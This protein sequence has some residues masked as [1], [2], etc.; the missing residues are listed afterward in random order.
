MMM[1]PE[2][3]TYKSVKHPLFHS[4]EGDRID[5]FCP[6]CMQS[7]DASLEENLVQVLMID[8]TG[9]EQMIF[10]SRMSGDPDSYQVASKDLIQYLGV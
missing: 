4:G 3:D 9:N 10:F 2:G 6:I 7:L 5:F 8:S 1:H